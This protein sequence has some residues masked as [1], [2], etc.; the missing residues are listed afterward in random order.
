MSKCKGCDA[1]IVWG[2]DEKGTRVPLDPRPPVYELLKFDPV[3]QAYAVERDGGERPRHYVSHFATCPDANK[4]SKAKK[5]ER[6]EPPD[7][8]AAAAG[9]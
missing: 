9:D 1:E 7:H 8:R 3:V 4:F 6:R 2:I 5:Q